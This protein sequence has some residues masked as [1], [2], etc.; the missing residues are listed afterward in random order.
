M[1]LPALQAALNKMTEDQLRDVNRIV[2]SAIR[3]R[4][5]QNSRAVMRSFRHGQIVSF[6]SKKGRMVKI[7]ID[8]FNEKSVSG[9]EILSDGSIGFTTW[10]VS[11]GLLRAA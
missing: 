9:T 10:R 5:R 11:P 6:W 2:C 3:D 1:N 4:M 7:R 8:R